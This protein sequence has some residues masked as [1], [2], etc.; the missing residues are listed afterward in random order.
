MDGAGGA[1]SLQ[2]LI[3]GTG[4]LATLFVWR[5]ARAGHQ[6]VLLGRWQAG[7]RALREKGARLVDSNGD[8]QAVPVAAVED[9]GKV[10][11]MKHAIVLVKSWQTTQSAQDLVQCLAPDGLAVTL[12]N[13]LGNYEILEEA[14]GSGR[15]ALGSTTAGATLLG[16]GLVKAAG[17]GTVAIQTHPRLRPLEAALMSSGFHVEVVQNANSLV[18]KKLIVN[19]AIN[20]LTALLRVPNGE[21]L[22]R[23]AA[24][25]LM[26]M[27]AQETAAV[28]AAEEIELQ[29]DDAAA[30]VEEVARNT[31]SNYSSMLQDIRRGTPT[32]ID[33]I[34]GAVSRA[35]QRHGVPTPMNTACWKLIQALRE[36]PVK[37]AGP[38]F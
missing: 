21:L 19:S 12:Q 24:R 1:E 25:A 3:V 11:G 23:P 14:L 18:W 20:P 10:R 27:L 36:A 2:I 31:A 17:E 8:E 29:L 26:R 30:M 33:A 15:V 34:C 16:P 37:P 13:G 22:R 9:P 28:A 32:E 6:P 7:L 35:G 38:D 4:A 5:L